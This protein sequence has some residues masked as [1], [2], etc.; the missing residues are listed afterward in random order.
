MRNLYHPLTPP[1]P[2]WASR[3]PYHNSCSCCAIG[4]DTRSSRG[5]S[6]REERA[7]S[8]STDLSQPKRFR[9]FTHILLVTQ[10]FRE[11]PR[12]R[13]CAW[14]RGGPRTR[15]GENVKTKRATAASL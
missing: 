11:C 6:V 14:G 2:W 5:E 7:L 15:Q 3:V 13:C 8:G 1:T 9:I 12:L 4:R 10:M